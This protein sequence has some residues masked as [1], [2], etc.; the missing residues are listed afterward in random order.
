MK[1]TNADFILKICF[2]TQIS[3]SKVVFQSQKSSSTLFSP[4]KKLLTDSLPKSFSNS[5]SSFFPR[6]F[7][8]YSWLFLQTF[9]AFC[10]D[11]TL[12]PQDF[13]LVGPKNG[14]TFRVDVTCLPRLPPVMH[15]SSGDFSLCIH[16]L[17]RGFGVT[18]KVEFLS[19]STT[20]RL[21]RLKK[22]THCVTVK[23]HS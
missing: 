10:W 8:P 23:V 16:F 9:F 18:S 22:C 14:S 4:R 15:E 3:F 17:T 12:F 6:C 19:R 21:A 1:F 7:E 20:W 5:Y 11:V 13:S 2:Q